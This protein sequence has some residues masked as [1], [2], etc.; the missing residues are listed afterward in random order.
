VPN[1]EFITSRL[2]NWTLSD[3]TTRVMVTVGVAYGSDIEEAMAIVIKTAK[4]HPQILSDPSPAVYFESL[5]DNALIINLRA[6]V[7]KHEHRL[8]T[9]SELHV[10]VYKALNAAEIPISYPQRDIHLDTSQ[11]LDI[12]LS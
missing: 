10:A 8:P 3:Q 2:L 9:R 11:P 4:D 12:R 7:G 1:K 5:G 6:Y